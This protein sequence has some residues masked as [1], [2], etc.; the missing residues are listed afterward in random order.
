MDHVAHAVR[1]SI[2]ALLGVVD[3]LPAAAS[4]AIVAA[5]TALVMLA[6]VRRTTPQRLVVRARSRIAASIYEMRLYLDDPRAVLAAQGR[7][8]GWSAVYLACILPAAI[9]LVVPLGLLYLE[10]EVRHGLAPF[11]PPA[12][13][14]VRVEL[15]D[16]RSSPDV[17]VEPL[18][19][20]AVT[21]VVRS[22]VEG[23]VYARVAIARPGT[24]HVIARLGRDAV[25]K[26][27]VADPGA[28]VV[29]PERRG[30]IARLWTLGT[31]PPPASDAIVGVSVQHPER[32]ARLPVPW[33]AYWLGLS[34]GF[35][36]LLRRRL[37]VAL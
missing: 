18:G 30:G 4:L 35:A 6:V 14:V 19:T 16:P 8:V 13:V 15:A 22:P 34:I 20:A 31:E 24:H 5:L 23:A 37:G 11:A 7:L 1:W 17:V 3:G 33:W 27:I 32:D 28:A 21:A 12:D 25:A 2:D 29:V 26:Q 9:V 36:L 10:L